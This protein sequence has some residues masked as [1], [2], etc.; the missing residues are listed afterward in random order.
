MAIYQIVAESHMKVG[1]Y[2]IHLLFSF[3]CAFYVF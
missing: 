3:M 2:V 1:V